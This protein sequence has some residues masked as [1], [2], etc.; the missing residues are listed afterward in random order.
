[1]FTAHARWETSATTMASEVVPL[2][3]GTFS[4]SPNVLNWSTQ[5]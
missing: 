3:M 4:P 1:M 5:L 2:A